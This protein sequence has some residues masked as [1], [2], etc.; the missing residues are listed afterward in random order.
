[1]NKRSA[2]SFGQH[3]SNVIHPGSGTALRFCGD[4]GDALTFTSVLFFRSGAR[5][6]N[7]LAKW[8]ARQSRAQVGTPTKLEV[9]HSPIVYD[10]STRIEQLL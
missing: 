3:D 4:S 9:V 1:M 2:T 7:R 8:V 6:P 10:T 5:K